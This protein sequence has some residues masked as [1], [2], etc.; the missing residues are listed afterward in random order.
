MGG[1]LCA[2]AR[3]MRL[4]VT[5]AAFLFFFLT[6]GRAELPSTLAEFPF[7]LRDG[8]IWIEVSSSQSLKPLH[9]MLD[10]GAEVSVINLETAQRLRLGMGRSVL[11]RG[12]KSVGRGYWPEHLSA[13]IGAVHLADNYLA[14]DLGGLSKVCHV[15]IDGL[16]G[17]DFFRK[18]L[19]QIDFDKRKIRLLKSVVLNGQEESAPLAVCSGGI[20]VKIQINGGKKQ[21]V[22]LDTG[23]ASPL[24]WVSP[25][26][27]ST[28]C[29]RQTAMSM[30]E[31]SMPVIDTSVQIGETKFSP[32]SAGLHINPIF[33]GEAGLLGVPLLSRFSTVTVDTSGSRLLLQKNHPDLASY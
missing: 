25:H 17:A 12:V 10:S 18:H 33:P 28:S 11:V 21:W 1:T 15:E 24:Q 9:F 26:D 14:V 2:I 27:S 13:S 31:V 4:A 7:Q 30:T 23:C 19:V 22:R 8:L 3:P 6:Q 29:A 32:V 16:L 20:R 5:I